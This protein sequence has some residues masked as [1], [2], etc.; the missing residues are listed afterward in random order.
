MNENV[1]S[2]EDLGPAPSLPP[3]V[4]SP[5]DNAEMVLVPAG[6]FI[7][8]ISEEELKQIFVLDGSQNAV[9]VTEVPRRK[10][11]WENFYIAIHPG[12]N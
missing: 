7:M 2:V 6:E 9:F 10:L 1:W 8:G 12:T 3:K 5:V 11:S 4:I